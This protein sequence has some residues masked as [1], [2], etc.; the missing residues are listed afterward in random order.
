MKALYYGD[1]NIGN[2]RP[3]NEDAFDENYAE[4]C[5]SYEVETII[6]EYGFSEALLKSSDKI[7]DYKGKYTMVSRIYSLK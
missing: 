2:I 3:K 5:F 7:E 6:N 4:E 1:T